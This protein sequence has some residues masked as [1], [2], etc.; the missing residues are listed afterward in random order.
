[1]C[2][3]GVTSASGQPLRRASSWLLGALLLASGACDRM[4]QMHGVMIEPPRAVSAYEFTLADGAR[5]TTAAER[6]RPMVLSFGYTHCPDVCPTTLADWKRAR[7][8][9]G[10]DADRVRFVFVTIDPERDT[11]ALAERYAKQFDASF[12]GVS[13]DSATTRRILADF[14][15]AA[16]REAPR[17]GAT[18][19][20]SFVNDS[21]YFMSHSAQGFLVDDKGR[22]V[23]IYPFGIGWKALLDDLVSLL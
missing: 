11:P 5:V 17:G 9:L 4:T 23:A 13:G 22:L 14:G 16:A 19:S 21:S 7:E 15:A 1:M 3:R 18:D 20:I 6:G 8:E 10:R 2:H 12:V